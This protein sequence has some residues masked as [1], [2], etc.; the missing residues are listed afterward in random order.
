MSAVPARPFRMA[1][2][3]AAVLAM[4]VALGWPVCRFFLTGQT[5][6]VQLYT[7]A[8]LSGTGKLYDPEANY[9]WHRR[10]FATRFPAVLHSRPPF[11]S[12]LLRPLGRL[13]Y[14]AAFFLF[15][16]LNLLAAVWVFLRVL[17]PN[18][19]AAWLALLNPA[20]YLA[21]LWGQDVWLA[22]AL[23]AAAWLALR[24]GRD[25]QAGMLLSLCAIKAHLFVLTPLALLLHRRWTVLAG[26]A[27]GAAAL[28]LV[29]FY[30][31]GIGWPAQYWRIL[32]N[33]VIH[34]DM[35]G[36][37]NL[38]G[39]A[40]L[41]GHP[42]GLLPFL[43]AATVAAVLWI[44]LRTDQISVAM[45]AALTGSFLISYHAY[46]HD[47]LT[48]LLAFALLQPSSLSGWR[49]AAWFLLAGPLPLWLVLMGKPWTA[50]LPAAALLALATLALVRQKAPATSGESL[51]ADGAS[52]PPSALPRAGSVRAQS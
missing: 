24:K 47:S 15:V 5:D 19:P 34:R 11:Y 7:G 29:S 2:I 52:T 4:V 6:F 16:S 31:E 3:A 44:S 14:L 27:A 17:G 48:L 12:F 41:L 45:A 21:L 32:S 20:A 42:P 37:P 10:L 1:A 36:M 33:P 39:V 22:V 46:P 49:R 13:P 40:S 51:A 23:C 28:L 38:Q 26:G 43:L 30:A 8:Q 18:R 50:S 9:G 25:F 35:A